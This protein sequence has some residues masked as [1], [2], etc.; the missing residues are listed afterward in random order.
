MFKLQKYEKKRIRQRQIP[1]KNTEHMES[2]LYNNAHNIPPAENPP[3][4]GTVIHPNGS[5]F[6][7]KTHFHPTEEV[8]SSSLSRTNFDCSYIVFI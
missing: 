3:Q 1:A 4:E 8:L 7:Q 5:S 2:M 6:T